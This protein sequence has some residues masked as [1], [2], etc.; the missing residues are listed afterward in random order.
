MRCWYMGMLI[1]CYVLL[2]VNFLLTGET[3]FQNRLQIDGII[4]R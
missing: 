1:K 3:L 4:I 2:L